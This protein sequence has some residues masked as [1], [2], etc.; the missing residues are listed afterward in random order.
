MDFCGGAYR[1]KAEREGYPIGWLPEVGELNADPAT[2]LLQVATLP[3]GFLSL[4]RAVFETLRAKHPE[5]G[6]D[7][8]GERFQAYFHCPPGCGEDGAFCADWRAAGGRVWLDP[9]LRLTH[10]GG[11]GAFTGRVGDFLRGREVQAA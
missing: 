7:F 4:S 8:G 10:V 9:E 3:G 5:R 2:G 6:Y 1:Y 11:R